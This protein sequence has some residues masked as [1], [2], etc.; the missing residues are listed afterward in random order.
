M[1]VSNLFC[2]CRCKYFRFRDVITRHVCIY[3]WYLIGVEFYL[4]LHVRW[5]DF[6]HLATFHLGLVFGKMFIGIE[7]HLM[8]FIGREP[9]VTRP[10]ETG[11]SSPSDYI[12]FQRGT[13]VFLFC[14]RYRASTRARCRITSRTSSERSAV[15][16]G[17]LKLM[18]LYALHV[19]R[20]NVFFLHK[21]QT[22]EQGFGRLPS[23][24]TEHGAPLPTPLA[25]RGPTSSPW[26]QRTPTV[27]RGSTCSQSSSLKSAPSRVH[28]PWR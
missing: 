12:I 5:V 25:C 14:C 20:V 4:R 21:I 24:F 15:A 16:A 10:P 18:P 23:V 8:P 27:G 1:A 13:E 17:S 28:W 19:K 7:D 26:R 3:T 11:A 22:K 6:L 2:T 9:R